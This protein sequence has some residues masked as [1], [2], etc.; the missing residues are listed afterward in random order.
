MAS[1]AKDDDEISIPISLSKEPTFTPFGGTKAVNPI[2]QFLGTPD[3]ETNVYI[4]S[5]QPFSNYFI[6]LN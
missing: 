2:E 6:F 3:I 5:F 1:N 4:L